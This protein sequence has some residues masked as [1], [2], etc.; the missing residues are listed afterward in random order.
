MHHAMPPADDITAF[1][2]MLSPQ[3]YTLKREN[4]AVRYQ[5]QAKK[6]APSILENLLPSDQHYDYYVFKDDESWVFIAYSPEE[7]AGFLRSRE[8]EAEGVSRLYFAQQ[9]VEKFTIPVLLD[10][11]DALINMQDTA[12]VIPKILLSEETKYQ[13]FSD[14]FRPDKG[15][16]LSVG[17]HS[18][19]GKKEGWIIGAIF[20]MFALMFAVEGVKYRQAIATM[21]QE[22]T[23]LLS[24]YPAI[25]S[26]YSRENIAQKYRKIDKAERRKREVLKGLSK[27]ILPGVEVESLTMDSKH[28]VAVFKCPDEK[29]VLRV[30]SL[31]KERAYNASRM[32]NS[33]P[34]KPLFVD[35]YLNAS[36]IGSGNLVKIE[37]KL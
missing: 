6:L 17:T 13:E 4:L 36:R 12:T 22:V 9:A 28:F 23:E 25:Q 33:N 30:Q 10:A 26:Q 34:P 24:D 29:S 32:G 21:Q 14:A 2:L 15:V 20:L 11:H 8:V 19:I 3:F 35:I 27:L 1:E 31:A 18:I 5:Y 7:I 37:G 16:S